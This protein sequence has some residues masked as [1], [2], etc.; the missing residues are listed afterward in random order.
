VHLQKAESLP[1]IDYDE[2]SKVRYETEEG[3]KAELRRNNIKF[4]EKDIRKGDL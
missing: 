2:S 4:N 1:G 3:L